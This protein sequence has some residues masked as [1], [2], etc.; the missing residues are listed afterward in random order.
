MSKWILIQTENN[1]ILEPTT[2]D[3]YEQAYEAMKNEY[4]ILKENWHDG[5]IHS[6]YASIQSDYENWDW[7]IYEVKC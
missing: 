4:D 1:D 5:N 7:R 2:Y 6:D 3:S